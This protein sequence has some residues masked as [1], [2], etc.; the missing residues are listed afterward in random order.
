MVFKVID[1]NVDVV[2]R[3]GMPTVVYDRVE[4]R[5]KALGMFLARQ[6]NLDI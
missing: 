6:W 1:N 3:G 4:E 5:L 2:D